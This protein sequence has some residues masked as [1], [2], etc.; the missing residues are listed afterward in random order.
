[1]P[2][3]IWRRSAMT[4][5]GTGHAIGVWDAA[6]YTGACSAA[7]EVI[8]TVRLPESNRT[9]V[10]ARPGLPV[11]MGLT[12]RAGL[13]QARAAARRNTAAGIAPSGATDAINDASERF[14]R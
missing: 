11:V 3:C 7:R 1:M 2:S 8:A 12:N 6:P 13:P 10:V 9:R 5:P 4:S 14:V